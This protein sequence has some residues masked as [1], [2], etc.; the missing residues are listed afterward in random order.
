MGTTLLTS[1]F[2]ALVGYVVGSVPVGLVIGRLYGVDPRQVGSGRTG[3]TNVYRAAGRV[4]GLLTAFLDFIK[5]AVAIL[6]VALLV[7]QEPL[8][9]ALAGLG[10]VAGHN[11]S[12][13]LGFRGGA[14]T[15]T[16]VGNV[17]VLSWPVFLLVC[18]AGP[19]ALYLSRMSSVASLVA[20]WATALLLILFAL[21]GWTPMAYIVYGIG[22]ALFI[23]WSLRPNI[24]RLASG[25]ERKLGDDKKPAH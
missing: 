22:Q 16:Q 10:A 2:A 4:A 24:Q 25:T 7:T 20:T 23:T 1:I 18:I 17:L 9:A 6:L 21:A 11:W 15:M 12:L 13:F 14:G 19:F 5:G 8:A 3:G